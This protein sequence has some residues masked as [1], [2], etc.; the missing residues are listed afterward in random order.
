[1][2]TLFYRAFKNL[3]PSNIYN[4]KYN[5]LLSIPLFFFLTNI[6]WMIFREQ[7]LTYLIKYF[8]VFQ[9][10]SSHLNLAIAIYLMVTL[11]LYSL[12]LVITSTY[13]FITENKKIDI[14]YSENTLLSLKIFFSL[15]LFISIIMFRSSTAVDFIYFQF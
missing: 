15:V 10:G 12:P 6:G 5:A 13:L 2:L 14:T 4:F 1:M 11:L 7:D 3:I 9:S 8:S